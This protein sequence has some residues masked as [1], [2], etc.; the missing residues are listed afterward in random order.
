[1]N[2]LFVELIPQLLVSFLNC[3]MNAAYSL[4]EDI[5]SHHLL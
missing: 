1:M 3:C 4:P 5:A 2:L